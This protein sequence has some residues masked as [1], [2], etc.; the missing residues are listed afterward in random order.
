MRY[1]ICTN[2]GRPVIAG[3]QTFTFEPVSNWGG[4]W[5]GVLAV[6]DDSSANILSQSGNGQVEE[7]TKDYYDIQKK[8]QSVV[9]SNST[10]SPTRPPFAMSAHAARPA[11]PPTGQTEGFNS[12]EMITPVTLLTTRA[13]PPREPL[14]EGGGPQPR[15]R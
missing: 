7:I 1:F 12:T 13:Q 4:S 9:S 8:K 2:A 6:E 14:L 11:A 3:G 10:V 5:L 15:R